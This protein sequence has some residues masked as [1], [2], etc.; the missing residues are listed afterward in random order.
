MTGTVAM[1]SSWL[2]RP[3]VSDHVRS[4]LEDVVLQAMLSSE[5]VVAAVRNLP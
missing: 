3:P 4:P 5:P 2:P 1:S